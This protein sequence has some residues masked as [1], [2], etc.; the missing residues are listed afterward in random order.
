M[1]S[2]APAGSHRHVRWGILPAAL[3]KRQADRGRDRKVAI[4]WERYEARSNSARYNCSGLSLK[5]REARSLRDVL[6]T[7]G[8]LKSGQLND[9]LRAHVVDPKKKHISWHIFFTLLLQKFSTWNMG[10][11]FGIWR[12]Y[13]NVHGGFLQREK[14][15]APDVFG[16]SKSKF[17]CL[18]FWE[19]IG[20][21]S[22][23][24]KSACRDT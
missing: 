14:P 22:L 24:K 7:Q 10:G 11:N 8:K 12:H 4:R 6:A 18:A 20:A 1:Y 3:Y 13:R 19:S 23:Q 15:A 21:Y 5:V 2:A 9:S 17:K 16:I